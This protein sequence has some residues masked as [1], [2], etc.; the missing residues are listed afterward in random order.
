MSNIR[1]QK[2]VEQIPRSADGSHAS[3]HL[4][5]PAITVVIIN[6]NTREHLRS[7]LAT[8]PQAAADDVIVVDNASSDGSV[9]MIEAEY[10][11]VTV[12][13]NTKNPGYGAAANQAIA[14][15]TSPYVLLL[16]SDTR[17]EPGAFQALRSYFDMHPS[18]A[19]VGPR[20]VN[21]D[22][23]LQVSCFP[24]PTPWN[25]FFRET[26]LSNLLRY[27]PFLR[28]R[29]LPTWSH[30]QPRTVPWVLGAAL[31]LRCEA[32]QAVGGFDESFFMYFEEVDLCHRLRAAGWQ[33]QFAPVTRVIH[34]GGASTM[35]H[36]ADMVVQL[37][38]SL[39]HFYERH[40]GQRQR[41]QLRLVVS[42]IM[43]RNIVRDTL[44]LQR[45]RDTAAYAERTES[46]A[47]WKRVLRAEWSSRHTGV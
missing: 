22:G 5:S 23:T 7:C 24:A 1:K 9:A 19:V 15:C 14:I 40:F 16:N 47:V 37:Y 28:D 18:V 26:R 45:A 31:A 34:I 46:I 38:A 41:Q 3:L 21:L 12:L 20:I 27:V 10:P 43:L 32:F 33:I 4:A 17:L 44:L 13:A 8:I 39:H 11:W 29:Y 25:T 2:Y 36:R 35:H 42:Y 6:Y 30:L